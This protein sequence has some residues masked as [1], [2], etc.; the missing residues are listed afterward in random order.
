[1]DVRTSI[2]LSRRRRVV[3]VLKSCVD[4]RTVVECRFSPA[5]PIQTLSSD[6][7]LLVAGVFPARPDIQVI[8][9][10][11]MLSKVLYEKGTLHLQAQI[12]VKANASLLR[13]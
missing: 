10:T 13:Y 9:F 7:K 4:V 8:L 3:K 6:M 1:M 2:L 5:F 12:I 11:R